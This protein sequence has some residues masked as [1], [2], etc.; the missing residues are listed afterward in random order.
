MIGLHHCLIHH[1][2][3]PRH[4]PPPPPP[5]KGLCPGRRAHPAPRYSGARVGV[6]TGRFSCMYYKKVLLR[7]RKRHTDRGVSSTT[8]VG[9]P[10][11][12]PGLSGGTQGGVP[13]CWGSPPLGYP[14]GQGTPQPGLMGGYPRWDTPLLGYPPSQV[15]WGG[16]LRWG[17]PLARSD[18]V[19]DVGYPPCQGTPGQVQWGGTCSGVPPGWGTPPPGLTGGT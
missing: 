18:G 8:K 7:E 15:L 12:R 1:G 13:P 6:P 16:Y 2:I 5:R 19:H 4:S 9:Y 11:H 14:P 10:P 3:E 17:T